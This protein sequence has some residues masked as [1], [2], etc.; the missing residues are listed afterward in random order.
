MSKNAGFGKGYGIGLAKLKID[1]G[2]FRAAFRS[3]SGGAE[4]CF[5]SVWVVK[6][7]VH[8]G[9]GKGG[10]RAEE[11]Q[12]KGRGAEE[13]QRK[14]RGSRGEGQKKGRGRAEGVQG[15]GGGRA[16]GRQGKAFLCLALPLVHMC[17]DLWIMSSTR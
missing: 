8:V 16:E 12:R 17:G 13:A 1:L 15:K 4:R 7:P 14:S 11:G 2:G 9:R 5:A 6:S 3:S 10:G